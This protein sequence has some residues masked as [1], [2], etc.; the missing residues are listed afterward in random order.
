MSYIDAAVV[1]KGK[2]VKVWERDQDGV[3][4]SHTYDAEYF[5]YV[6]DERGKQ[7][8]IFPDRFNQASKETFPDRQSL[9]KFV[10]EHNRSNPK[11]PLFES[12][13]QPELRVLSELYY[14]A[15]VPN[16]HIT[17]FD[18]EVDADLE[19]RGWPTLDD[20]YGD[21]TSVAFHHLWKNETV[22]ISTPPEEWVGE[23]PTAEELGC[24]RVIY[25]KHE[26][27]L[28]GLLIQEIED[29]DV[30]SAYNG[31]VFDVPYII[32]SLGVHIGKDEAE[33][34]LC[35]DG[36][37]SRKRL[38]PDKYGGDDL[39]TYKLYGRVHIDYMD[40]YKKYTYSEL[41]SYS[42]ENVGEHELGYGKLD[43][44][45]TLPDLYRKDYKRF[46]KYNLHDVFLL[47]DLEKK[48]SFLDILNRFAHDCC[49]KLPDVMGTVTP[50][51]MA[52]IS[53]AHHELG[54]VI[55]D[56]S[57]NVGLPEYVSTVAEAGSSSDKYAGAFVYDMDTFD[58]RYR[59]VSTKKGLHGYMGSTDITSEYPKSIIANNI[60]LE[61]ITPFAKRENG[62][63]IFAKRMGYRRDEIDD[64]QKAH[65]F[66]VK[67]STGKF[68][69]NIL[70]R[71]YIKKDAERSG[72]WSDV[73]RIESYTW[74]A[75]NDVV[76]LVPQ[77]LMMWFEMRLEF[78]GELKKHYKAKV[79]ILKSYGVDIKHIPEDDELKGII[80]DD[81]EQYKFH[82]GKEGHFDRLQHIRKIALNSLYGAT[83]NAHSHFYNVAA[84]EACTLCG[85]GIVSFMGEQIAL[86]IDGV[87]DLRAPHIIYGDTDSIYFSLPDEIDNDEDAVI[88]SD[89][90]GETVN[91]LFYDYMK[92][93]HNCAD[94]QAKEISGDRE[95]VADRALFT[96]KKRYA[97]HLIDKDGN[98]CDKLK[99]MGL[100][101]IKSTTPVKVKKFLKDILTKLLKE[102]KGEDDLKEHILNF[103]HE[104]RNEFTPLDFGEP[105]GVK[106]IEDYKDRLYVRG[107]VDRDKKGANVL[108]GEAGLSK[109]ELKAIR[110]AKSDVERW[111]KIIKGN[112]VTVP[113]HVRGA[114]NWNNHLD[115]IGDR[116][117]A[118]AISGGKIRTYYLNEKN[119]L[120]VINI[121]IPSDLEALPEW[122]TELPFNMDRIESNLID[123]KI[124][125]LYNAIG[126]RVPTQKQAEAE[127]VFGF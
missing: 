116:I 44:T 124:E 101:V 33:R 82:D 20:P 89:Y 85:Q 23:L 125:I 48:L 50:T 95:V 79:K 107:L 102:K 58:A 109:T 56:K 39:I 2:N 76:G 26:T 14:K 61:T 74:G 77:I 93:T 112:K 27:E 68:P 43:Y 47:R 59:V 73:E 99:I 34:A 75:R 29:T 41:A 69:E 88:Y 66:K 127:S 5:C 105:M 87:A 126:W 54:Q 30:L 92:E 38:I 21:I 46:L 110:S 37:K 10:K 111:G 64:I 78:K 115:N 35:R 1:D 117:T 63:I 32:A 9:K 11:I 49:C 25:T 121:A 100:D 42:L 81:F 15:D 40:L 120:G 60:S 118:K 94:W 7:K 36:L 84:A 18:I 70:A 4:T 72:D 119:D 90:I 45:G 24:D 96:D 53:F 31:D 8:T 57:A 19:N 71:T 98:P 3:L 113:G 114:M 91:V 22:L 51:D 52:L 83:G 108:T 80:G 28:L 16:P 123:K 103:R 55:P 86:E 65:E 97:M 12:D 106:G 17:F 104:L 6:P 67:C 13:I 122:F 62:D